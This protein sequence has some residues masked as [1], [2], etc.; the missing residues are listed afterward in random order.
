MLKAAK[1][2]ESS[3]SDSETGKKIRIST[4]VRIKFRANYPEEFAY[5]RNARLNEAIASLFSKSAAYVEHYFKMGEEGSVWGEIR[6][7]GS[8]YFISAIRDEYI[9]ILT[10]QDDWK[11]PKNNWRRTERTASLKFM[12]KKANIKAVWPQ[13]YR[14]LKNPPQG[15]QLG[16]FSAKLPAMN[17]I[18]IDD[19]SPSSNPSAI[20]HVTTEDVDG[21]GTLDVIHISS[22][23]LA[24]ELNRIGI[25]PDRLSNFQQL[26]PQDLYPV[27]GAFVELISHEMGHLADYSGNIENPFPGGEGAADTAAHRA[28]Q[29]MR[30]ATTNKIF[31]DKR[32]TNMSIVLNTLKKLANELDEIRATKLA[33]EVTRLMEK[34]AID[35]DES[36]GPTVIGTHGEINIHGD[37]YTYNFDENTQRLTVASVTIPEDASSEQS[38]QMFKAIEYTFSQQSNPQ[39]WDNV[40]SRPEFL[41]LFGNRPR[42]DDKGIVRFDKSDPTA[43][44]PWMRKANKGFQN[45]KAAGAYED[46]TLDAEGRAAKRLE[47]GGANPLLT[48]LESA[49]L[50][51]EVP[52]MTPTGDAPFESQIPGRPARRVIDSELRAEIDDFNVWLDNRSRLSRRRFPHPNDPHEYVKQ[53]K[54]W[55]KMKSLPPVEDYSDVLTN[56]KLLMESGALG[57]ESTY[58]TP[59]AISIPGDPFTYN[60]NAADSS[61]TVASYSPKPNTSSDVA[62]RNSQAIGGVITDAGTSDWEIEAWRILSSSPEVQAAIVSQTSQAD[63]STV[64]S[65]QKNEIKKEAS[66]KLN[67]EHIFD[68]PF[69]RTPF[70]RDG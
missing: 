12:I 51:A 55:R 16:E 1:I 53:F 63:D 52:N 49:P 37:P 36:A 65:G 27:L 8:F 59:G 61:F 57:R 62:S 60:Y 46:Q 9:D 68:V 44:Y 39:A 14:M 29:Q 54:R 28:I 25:G 26:S 43:V 48:N 70:R 23:R 19:G 18:I 47:L 11:R 15:I 4:T 69:R 2:E 3:M 34:I 67:L 66:K 40:V 21:D 45:R 13:V 58:G 33:D 7:G 30:I 42:T 50:S 5:M 20:G 22:Q 24:Q 56:M 31:R 38:E 64:T 10:I 32:G 17:K 41:G 35:L 6:K